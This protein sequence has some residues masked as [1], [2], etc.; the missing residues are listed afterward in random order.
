L[1][2]EQLGAVTG[3]VENL[4]LGNIRESFRFYARQL[5]S[6]EE[7]EWPDFERECIAILTRWYRSSGDPTLSVKER[8]LAGFTGEMI[9]VSRRY[10]MRFGLSYLLF[11]RT[12]NLLNA[13]LWRLAPQYNLLEKL[14][15][16]FE[17]ELPS[18]FARGIRRLRAPGW[19][20]N[21]ARLALALP[22]AAR[23]LGDRLAEADSPLEIMTYDTSRS[24][25]QSNREAWQVAAGMALLSAALAAYP[26][27]G[28]FF[29]RPA[30][31]GL[32]LAIVALALSRR[33]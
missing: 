9:E 17:R 13:S 16:F 4:A 3:M 28:I 18:P 23:G 30:L 22:E 12:L 29:L 26:L 15:T 2:P 6:T 11:W 33:R 10:R 24:S 20:A 21:T 32:A 1:T 19:R 27:H 14:R 25:H 5:A 7:S 31:T 8:H